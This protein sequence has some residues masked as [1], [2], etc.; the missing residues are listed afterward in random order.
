MNIFQQRS[1]EMVAELASG[2]DCIRAIYIFGSVA[3]GETATADD[4]DLCV[5]YVDGL[6]HSI[7]L[8][9]SYG[10]FQSTFERWA[11]EKRD[12]IARPLDFY[13]ALHRLAAATGMDILGDL[14]GRH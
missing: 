3:R 6:P 8:G 2:F 5:E 12:F 13:E 11:N 7:D 9:E 14:V 1:L 4:L 10:Q